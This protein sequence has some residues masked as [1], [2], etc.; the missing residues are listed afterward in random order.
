MN[1]KSREVITRRHPEDALVDP[2]PSGL[3]LATYPSEIH[4][5]RREHGDVRKSRHNAAKNV[6][7]VIVRRGG[8]LRRSLVG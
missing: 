7:A 8:Y 2:Q 1:C 3:H 4:E 6:V 5:K